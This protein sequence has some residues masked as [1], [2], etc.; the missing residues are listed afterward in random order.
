M[1][2]APG[3]DQVALLRPYMEHKLHHP[4]R[5]A[6]RPAAA[7]RHNF[8][9]TMYDQ[10]NLCV[11]DETE[12]LRHPTRRNQEKNT[13]N[14]R[15][16]V[17]K[18]NAFTSDDNKKARIFVKIPMTGK[19][20]AF[21]PKKTDCSVIATVLPVRFVRSLKAMRRI[22]RVAGVH[23]FGTTFAPHDAVEDAPRA[24]IAATSSP[25]LDEAS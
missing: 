20:S 6:Q 15:V 13:L 19:N 24:G 17:E 5:P 10:L 2:A 23:F 3:D 21:W 1:R 8:L 4:V 9:V 11:S 7:I 22:Y 14:K 16:K 25:W 12:S 18:S